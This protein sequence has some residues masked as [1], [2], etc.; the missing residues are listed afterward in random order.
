MISTN[1]EVSHKTFGKGVILSVSGKYFTVKFDVAQKTF[2]YP[3]AFENFL[4]L[5][6]GTVSDEILLDIKGVKAE[7]QRI[8]DAKNAEDERAKKMGTVIP[9]KEMPT[10]N[11]DEESRFKNTDTEEI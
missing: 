6:D 1:V 2:V 5:S 7:R 3:D 10:D 4:T 8:I 9:G 11:E